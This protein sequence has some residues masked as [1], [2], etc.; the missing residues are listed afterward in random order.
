[1][2]IVDKG[3]SADKPLLPKVAFNTLRTFMRMCETYLKEKKLHDTDAE[4]FFLCLDDGSK[5]KQRAWLE[6]L[7]HAIVYA[8]YRVHT[9]L[10]E[11]PHSSRSPKAGSDVHPS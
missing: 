7:Q 10:G 3:K 1:V 9:G 5:S 11:T 2:Y 6:A 4:L 8:L